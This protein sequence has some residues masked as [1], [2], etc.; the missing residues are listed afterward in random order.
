MFS[1]YAQIKAVHVSRITDWEMNVVKAYTFQSFNIQVFVRSLLATT[2][3]V[4]DELDDRCRA[5]ENVHRSIFYGGCDSRDVPS[6]TNWPTVSLGF[7]FCTHLI[8]RLR[9]S[10]RPFIN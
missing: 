4:L 9:S 1:V 8:R 5:V 2:V 7:V 10:K 6:L 3:C